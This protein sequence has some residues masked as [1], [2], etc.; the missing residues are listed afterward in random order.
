MRRFSLALGLMGVITGC[1]SPVFSN[2]SDYPI[3]QRLRTSGPVLNGIWTINYHYRLR[4]APDLSARALSGTI[5]LFHGAAYPIAGASGTYRIG[6][7]T[8]RF[9]GTYMDF[10]TLTLQMSPMTLPDLGRT[11]IE[12]TLTLNETFQSATG[13]AVFIYQTASGTQS[14]AGIAELSRN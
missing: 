1:A 5:D 13:S 14:I 4:S 11:T 6:S 7:Q 9:E 3:A 12:S 8:G 2:G 10:S